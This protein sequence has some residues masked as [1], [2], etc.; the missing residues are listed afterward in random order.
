MLSY[1]IQNV[2]AAAAAAAAALYPNG[3]KILLANGLGTFFIKGKTV[4]NNISRSL[5]KKSPD[6]PILDN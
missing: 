1:P 6:C 3:I 5:P 2:F 4:F